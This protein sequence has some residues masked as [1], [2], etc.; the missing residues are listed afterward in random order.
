MKLLKLITLALIIFAIPA[1]SDNEPTEEKNN[2]PMQIGLTPC[3]TM[4]MK[5]QNNLGYRLLKA[6][7][8]KDNPVSTAISP[9]SISQTLAMLANGYDGETLQEIVSALNEAGTNLDEIN[10]YYKKLNDGIAK[11]DKKT[12]IQFVNALWANSS[13]SFNNNF[14]NTN[15]EYYGAILQSFNTFGDITNW[16]KQNTNE[17]IYSAV[18]EILKS[19]GPKDVYDDLTINNTTYFCGQWKDKFSVDENKTYTF[20]GE[21]G[22]KTVNMM[23][24][25]EYGSFYIGNNFKAASLS[26]GNGA[27][28]MDIILPDEGATVSQALDELINKD[29][30]DMQLISGNVTITMP[31]FEST[32]TYRI[33]DILSDV[34][35]SHLAGEVFPKMYTS[36]KALSDYK[37]YI[38]V[39]VDEKGTE[40][41]VTTSTIIGWGA[42][43]PS[44]GIPLTLLV[45][46]PFLW[47]IKECTSGTVLFLGKV[48]DV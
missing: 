41:K 1:C 25:S 34:G 36:A 46:R 20:H 4:T 5:K 19:N 45:D 15:K 24:R 26:Y 30:K 47:L 42:F 31:R 17:P 27:F 2:P 13:V 35:I 12:K 3:E 7:L 16:Y 22:D 11:T 32:D 40:V 10:E 37:Q 6:R 9:Y 33:L 48:G 8:D 21:N 23:H 44:E 14:V 39:K 38:S 29:L 18:A 28:V 43:D